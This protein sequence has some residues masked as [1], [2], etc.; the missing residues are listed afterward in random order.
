MTCVTKICSVYRNKGEYVN[1][2]QGHNRVE[3]S[4]LSCLCYFDG[5]DYPL[6]IEELHTYIPHVELTYE[7]LNEKLHNYPLNKLI[8]HKDEYYYLSDRDPG[9]I[10]RRLNAERIAQKR[11][12]TAKRMA[13][14][15]KK[16]PFVRAVMISGDLSKNVSS[17]E[18]DIDY[19]ILTEPDRLWITRTLLILFKKTVL[20][21]DRSFYCLNFF[22]T[23]SHLNFD[24][25]KDYFTATEILTLKTVYNTRVFGRLLENNQWVYS[26]FPNYRQNGAD[27]NYSS[28]SH[29]V[30]Q[31]IFEKILNLLPLDRLDTIVMNYM[32]KIWRKRYAMLSEDEIAYRF[33]CTKDES[34]AFVIE[35]KRDIMKKHT[36]RINK[37]KKHLN[38]TSI[39]H[40]D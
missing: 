31:V 8:S 12:R 9:I 5:F 23:T 14:I 2:D 22:R 17:A 33:R 29:S 21:N 24:N 35:S 6:K 27:M 20:L 40:Y 28:D 16:F 34:T 26:F 11:W 39:K 32:K 25:A 1:F 37:I 3:D 36:M 4:I 38:E 7:T 10:S 13:K 19:F 18:S 15:I 30:I